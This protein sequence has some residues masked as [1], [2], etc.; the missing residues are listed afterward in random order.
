MEGFILRIS[1]KDELVPCNSN[2]WATQSTLD[3]SQEA[4]RHDWLRPQASSFILLLVSSMPIRSRVTKQNTFS[5]LVGLRLTEN[6]LKLGF[7]FFF[8]LNGF[9][10]KNWDQPWQSGL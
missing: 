10:R 8:T 2:A 1:K 5:V 6:S 4:E 3:L 9:A 7:F